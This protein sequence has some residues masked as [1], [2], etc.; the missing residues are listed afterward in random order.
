[1]KFGGNVQTECNYVVTKFTLRC[2]DKLKCAQ[3]LFMTQM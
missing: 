2:F 1:M 3:L